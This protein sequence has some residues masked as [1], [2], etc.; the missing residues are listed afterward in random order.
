METR[1]RLLEATIALLRDRGYARITTRQ[2]VEAADAHLPAVNY[3]FGS[4]ER[5]MNE[6]VE[7]ALRRWTRSTMDAVDAVDAGRP[8]ERLRVGIERCLSTL[9]TDRGSVVAAVEAFAQA[10]RSDELRGSL[11][12]LYDE[13]RRMVAHAATGT[14]DDDTE[15]RPL[16][17]DTIDLASVLIALLDGLA[18]QGL[19]APDDVPGTDAI[20]R[21]LDLLAAL[22]SAERTGTRP[23]G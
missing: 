4:K 17:Q 20:L 6:A 15:E 1:E 2:I 7:E 18:I 16:T 21:S 9:A 22:L 5:L 8:R 14:S 19:L 12:G 3:F 11:A 10:E 23:S 13:C